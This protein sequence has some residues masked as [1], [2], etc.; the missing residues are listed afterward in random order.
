MKNP[1]NINM[2]NTQ[3]YQPVLRKRCFRT[4]EGVLLLSGKE[5]S[6]KQKGAFC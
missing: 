1:N 6:N 4:V 5:P 2:N 3:F